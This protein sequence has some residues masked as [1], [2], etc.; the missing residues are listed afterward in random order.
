MICDASLPTFQ[1]A[2]WGH[3]RTRGALLPLELIVRKL[4][5]EPADLY[6]M[7]DRGRIAVGQRA[8]LNVIDLDRLGLKMPRM[9]HDLPSGAGRLL[10]D[11][12]GYLATL[13]AGVATRR[14][15]ADTGARPGRL[16]RAIA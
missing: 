7:A 10:Q 14:N 4:T 6:G 1:V 3:K 12:E 16:L 2:Y 9:S 8:D 15:D 5:A 13:V 11:S